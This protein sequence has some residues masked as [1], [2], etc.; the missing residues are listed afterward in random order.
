MPLRALFLALATLAAANGSV[1]AASAAERELAAPE[2][3]FV[4]VEVA[5]VG[6]S[7]PAGSPVVLLRQPE[8]SEV[9]PIFIGPDQARA[10]LLALR[11]AEP[12]RPMTHDL[13]GNV[14]GALEATLERVYVDTII[15]NTFF[16]MLE[17]AV[18]GRNQPLRV[19]TRPSDAIALALRVG[20][21][22]HVAP[23]VLEQ[24][25]LI[26]YRGL[27]DRQQVVKAVGITVMAPTSELRRA[28]ELPDRDGLVVSD[29]TG[30]ARGAGLEAGALVLAVN[31]TTPGSPMEFLELVRATPDAERVQIR[32]WLAGSVTEIEVPTTIPDR[33]GASL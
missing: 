10:I 7:E 2:D 25:R 29:V 12:P 11:G 1:G 4:E 19:D 9:I 18:E 16:G 21:S 27:E 30:P 22:I 14:I 33:P 5:T 3:E 17:L 32:Y 15:D 24:A 28:L 8:G 6:L 23:Q 31:G 20:A 26:S 13:L